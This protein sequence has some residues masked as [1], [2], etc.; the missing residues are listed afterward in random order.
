VSDPDPPSEPPAGPTGDDPGKVDRAF[1]ESAIRPR[2]GA[3]RADVTLG[4]TYGVDFGVVSVGDRALVTAT[5]PVSVLPA[6]G[7]ERAGRF[8]MEVVL[9][10]VAVSGLPPTHVAV[11]LHL[12]PEMSDATLRRTWRGMSDAVADV[13]AAVVTGHTGR[14][15]GC[16]LTWVGAATAMA[17]GDPDDVVR[18]DGA[19]PGDRLLVTKGPAIEAA[20]LLANLFP[21][22]LRER[23]DGATT[24]RGRALVERATPVRDALVAAAAGPVTAMHDATER[25]LANALHETSAAAGVGLDLDGAA[26]P[27][28]PT[29]ET[30]CSASSAGTLLVTVRPDGVDGVLDALADEGITAAAV[31][32]VVEGSGVRVDGASLDRPT[33]DSFTAVYESLLAAEE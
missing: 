19:R 22:R 10:D 26:V 31:G 14:Y 11:G 30:V 27:L 29:V 24:E 17:V 1:F 32:R 8:A 2:L 20:A 28:D 33:R 18:P 12:P 3:R 23:T 13:G 6:L 16:S 5:D 4:P 9:A 21:D 25:G 15:A 7:W